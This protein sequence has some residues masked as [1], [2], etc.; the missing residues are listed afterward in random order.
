M[1]T[2]DKLMLVS[3]LDSIVILDPGKFSSRYED[4]ELVSLKMTMKQPFSLDIE[5]NYDK[6]EVILEFTGK[7]LGERYPELI[8]LNTIQECFRRINALGIFEIDMEKMMSAQVMKCDVTKDVP[9]TDISALNRFIRG[10]IKNYN[11]YSCRLLLN[12]NLIVEKNVTGRRYKR[13]ITLYDKGKE[14]MKSDRQDFTVGN[15]LQDRFDGLCRFEMN[16]TSQQAIRDTLGITGATLMEVLRSERNPIEDFLNEVLQDDVEADA[17]DTWK[18][19]CQK[20]VL[21]DCDYDMAKVEA[22][23]RYY[24]NGG[25]KRAK[26]PYI[27]LLESLTGRTSTWTKQKVLDAVK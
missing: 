12:G 16:L 25:I 18:T 6:G 17:Q 26:Q 3:T 23:L 1:I 7:V 19:Y 9:V 14:M 2:F 10:H 4:D 22:R 15:G 5:I 20:L 21:R 13:R 24:K 11:A 8:S 27:E